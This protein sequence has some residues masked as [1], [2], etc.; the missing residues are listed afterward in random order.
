[1]RSTT[2]GKRGGGG[3]SDRVRAT[4]SVSPHPA[5]WGA[6]LLFSAF[7]NA[8]RFLP[9]DEVGTALPLHDFALSVGWGLAGC[10]AALAGI[11]VHAKRAGRR[12]PD[13]TRNAFVLT[14]SLLVAGGLLFIAVPYAGAPL[15]PGAPVAAFGGA[16]GAGCILLSVA[17]GSLFAQL[18]PENLLFNS[19]LGIMV[20]AVVHVLAAPISPS[21]QGLAL[22]ACSLAASIALLII[23]RSSGGNSND[24]PCAP[25]DIDHP[26]TAGV[27]SNAPVAA[28]RVADGD[29]RATG[30]LAVSATD[31][32][33]SPQNGKDGGEDG[34]D[35]ERLHKALAMLWMPL[36]GACITCFIFGLTWDPIISNEQMR[37]PDP[38]GA[39]KS[40]IGPSLLAASVALV[41]LHKEDSSPL[42]LLNHA[43][44]PVAV[45]FLL[46][47]PT[48][49]TDSNLAAAA[50]DVLSQAS[51]A[52]IALAIWCSMASAARSVPLPAAFVFPS[53]LALLALAFAGGLRGIAVIGT[54]GRTICL[55]M[56]AGYL[57]LIAISFAQGSRQREE[58][59]TEPRGA[60]D[61]RT[62]IHRRCDA[63]AA[64]RHL[65]PR[66]REVLYY[67]GR[68]Y[69]HGYVAEK[70]YISENTVRTHVRHIYG[71]LEI[72]SREEL[73][74]LIDGET[75]SAVP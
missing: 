28:H 26:A 74:A 70:L 44:Y 21:P 40:L 55:V 13:L 42:R 25:D 43:M 20:T 27:S 69:N 17:W 36:A 34:R 1:M 64:E 35:R 68:G 66:E 33:D 61:S 53:C 58:R 49:S 11:A 67:L 15:L 24:A 63:L 51:F 30:G 50:I 37:L 9:S 7:L 60:D 39:L 22:I 45:A 75:P 52:V 6:G 47:L 62:Y 16:F 3:R 29:V 14:A 2:L 65:S 4:T 12:A 38:L 23:A 72:G 57:A 10:S 19:A 5:L 56:L 59:R 8:I 73:L 54:D 71:K 41:A 46:A 18:E 32:D 48:I 31:S